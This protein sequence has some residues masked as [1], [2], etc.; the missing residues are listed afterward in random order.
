MVTHQIRIGKDCVEILDNWRHDKE[1]LSDAIR[2]MDRHLK[3][4]KEHGV[5]S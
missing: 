3:K 5:K 2:R 1:S 4:H